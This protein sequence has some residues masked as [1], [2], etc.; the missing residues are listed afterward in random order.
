[1]P[2]LL[3]LSGVLT[4]I[5]FSK[6][7]KNVTCNFSKTKRMIAKNC[8]LCHFMR[9]LC[10]RRCFFAKIEIQSKPQSDIALEKR[11]IKTRKKQR[12]CKKPEIAII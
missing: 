1:L 11:L 6:A 12:R 10:N 8:G 5:P 2:G 3:N 7:G 4:P 9:R